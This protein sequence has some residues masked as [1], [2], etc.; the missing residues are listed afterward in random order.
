MDSVHVDVHLHI[1]DHDRRN[2]WFTQVDAT[3]QLGKAIGPT[4]AHTLEMSNPPQ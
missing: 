1:A 4:R 3:T 2:R